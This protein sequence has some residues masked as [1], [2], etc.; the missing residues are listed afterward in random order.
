VRGTGDDW[1]IFW[2]AGHHVGNAA[3]LTASHFA[4]TPAAAWLLWPLAHL[5]LAAGYFAYVALM[6]AAT[7]TAAWLASRL[8]ALSLPV[9]ALMA[10]AWGPLTIAVCLGQNSPFALLLV[11]LSIFAI[12]RS[13]EPLAGIAVGLL[14]YKPSDAVPLLFLL[15]ILKQWRSIG[16]AAICAAGWYV[17]SASATSDWLWPVP[18]AHMLAGLYRSD[19]TMNADFAISVP[20]ILARLGA[21]TLLAWAAGAAI[22]VAST[23]FLLRV[24]RLEAASIVPLIGLAASPHA[25]GYEAV[26]A[27]PALWLMATRFNPAR[28]AIIAVAYAIAPIYL[29]A[30]QLHFDALAVPVLGGVTIWFAT[31]A[32]DLL[33]KTPFRRWRDERA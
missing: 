14:L 28:A 1:K 6:L 22:L 10:L 11:T 8:Y 27:L 26:L 31:Q 21:P 4:Y 16:I 29:L 19:D 5:S 13:D 25:W 33:A 2:N 12:V 30:R 23:P 32:R 3:L 9:A 24:S 15:L 18:Y 7:V 17:L 20:T